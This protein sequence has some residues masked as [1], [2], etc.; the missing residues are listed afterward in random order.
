MEKSTP[1]SK[2]SDELASWSDLNIKNCI[3]VD[4]CMKACP[5]VDHDLSIAELNE[6][7]RQETPLTERVLAFTK[8]CIQCGRCDA[9][10]PTGAGR[11]VMMLSL[12][13]K[14]NK[15]GK[16]PEGYENYFA[17]KGY[18]KSAI[19][20]GGFNAIMKTKWKVSDPEKSATIAP[21]LDKT[22][23]KKADLLIYLGCYAF[24][25]EKSAT[26]TIDIAENLGFDF[27]VLGGLASC[28]GWPSL[29]AGRTEEAERYHQK[30]A[31][32]IEKSSPKQ[33]VTGCAECYM[34]LRKVKEKYNMDFEPLT[35]P[36]WLLKS[37]DEL[38][39]EKSDKKVT[40]HDSCNISRKC[41]DPKPARDLLGRMS[42]IVEMGRS[43]PNDTFC[44]GYWGLD[45]DPDG[46]K[47]IRYSRYAE[48]KS[49]GADMMVVECVTCL[50]SFVRDKDVS[51]VEVRDI[52]DLVHEGMKKR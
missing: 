42:E 16:A 32:L 41:G 34:S 44:C 17:L 20:R 38:G 46:Q 21:H 36:K 1:A 23:F 40:F 8:K 29:M 25:N 45:A 49:T 19:R 18:D 51:G 7:T 31:E 39:L 14:M 24:T 5:V 9:V 12:K 47:D 43:G 6:A 3:G 15:K 50:E 48:A 2:F 4:E 26:Q 52:V 22:E 27:E 28:C 13:E 33:I 30:L 10:C 11:S 35:T 37:V